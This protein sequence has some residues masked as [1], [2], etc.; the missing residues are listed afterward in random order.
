MKKIYHHHPTKIPAKTSPDEIIKPSYDISHISTGI[1]HLGL[2]AIHRAHQA[3]YTDETMSA[4]GRPDWGIAAASLQSDPELITNLHQQDYW[5]TVSE[6]DDHSRTIK[7]VGAIIEAYAARDDREPLLKVMS[8]PSTRIVTLTITEKGY[9]LQ[10]VNN[11]LNC[12]HPS[13]SHD[14]KHP[15]HPKTAVG[16]IVEALARRKKAG[17]PAFTVLSCDNMSD[18]GSLTRSAVRELARQNNPDLALW[19][20]DHVPFPSCIVDRIV[21]AMTCTDLDNVS[22]WIGAPDQCA[23][24]TEPF[25][26]W[27]I[28]DNFSLGRPD[29][30]VLDGVQFVDDVLPWQIMKLRLLNGS[31]SLLA[32]LGCL[33]G[34]ETIADAMDNTDMVRFIQHYMHRE[35]IPAIQI[36]P[37]ADVDNYSRQLLYRFSNKT[38]KHRTEQVAS[39]GSQKIPIR[40]LPTLSHLLQTQRS[41][42]AIALG[43]AAWFKYLGGVNEN[44]QTIVVNDPM[45]DALRSLAEDNSNSRIVATLVKESGVFPVE[46]SRSPTV[47]GLITTYYRQLSSLGVRQTLK[48]FNAEL[49]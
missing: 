23:V 33:A 43:I 1:V 21:P 41:F 39:D 46:V 47:I 28:E 37:Q 25:R 14:I 5:Y 24:I 29:W 42:N 20:N 22:Q 36:P 6:C 44:Q 8:K 17:V 26:Q 12:Q 30:D 18:N 32:Y 48:K 34:Y 45:V 10:P 3:L 7:L 16:I 4:T 11:Q 40:W 27:I 9:C 2:S 13:I 19:I 31:H 38:L 35:A 15:Q 49:C